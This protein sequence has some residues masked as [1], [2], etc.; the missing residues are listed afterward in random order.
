MSK[1]NLIPDGCFNGDREGQE[2]PAGIFCS[3]ETN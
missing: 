2:L 1:M 3:H